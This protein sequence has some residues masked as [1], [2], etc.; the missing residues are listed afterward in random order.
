LRAG[1][2]VVAA[3][4]LGPLASVRERGGLRWGRD[5]LAS[6]AASLGGAVV[7][8]A[9]APGAGRERGDLVRVRRSFCSA[10]GAMSSRG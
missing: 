8:A 9:A 4:F 1:A 3:S 5:D 10:A 7:F 2:F 6:V